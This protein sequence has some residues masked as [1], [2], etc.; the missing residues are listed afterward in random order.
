MKPMRMRADIT[1]GIAEMYGKALAV[2]RALVGSWKE[3][4]AFSR[5]GEQMFAPRNLKTR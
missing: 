1:A 5:K 3:L 2:K 4:D